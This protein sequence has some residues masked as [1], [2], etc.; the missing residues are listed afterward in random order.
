MFVWCFYLLNSAYCLQITPS[1]AAISVYMCKLRF[2][3]FCILTFLQCKLLLGIQTIL[4]T[5]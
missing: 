4:K 5:V 2:D 1:M 3:Y